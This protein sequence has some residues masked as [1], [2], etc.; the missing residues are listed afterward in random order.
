MSSNNTLWIQFAWAKRTACT[1]NARSAML[2]WLK[3]DRKYPSNQKQNVCVHK[4]CAVEKCVNNLGIFLL[5]M[6]LFLFSF[7][8]LLCL[9][10]IKSCISFSCY[11]HFFKE[12]I[13]TIFAHQL[14]RWAWLCLSD[15]RHGGKH[16]SKI[17]LKQHHIFL[18][19]NKTS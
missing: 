16:V 8:K 5:R 13:F 15:W 6:H 7:T 11:D 2:T 12:L 3:N 10:E 17:W 9:H 19:W 4:T 18:S 14:V 1:A